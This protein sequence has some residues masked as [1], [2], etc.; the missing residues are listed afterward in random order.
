MSLRICSRDMRSTSF[1]NDSAARAAATTQSKIDNRKS[2][3]DWRRGQESNLP[4]LLRTD[5]GVE[6]REGHQAPFTLR[7]EEENAERSTF[8]AQ[9]RSKTAK[10]RL[11]G[12]FKLFNRAD[13]GVELW[14]VTGVEFGMEQLAIGAD[15]EGAAT[16]RDE[17][18]RLNA[19]AEL[20]NFGRQTD[21]L[22]R[23][24]SDDAVFDRYFGFH[25]VLL[26]D[27][28]VSVRQHAVKTQPN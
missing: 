19:L 6:D 23:V 3:M 12:L 7:E 10:I 27:S 26:S 9:R 13:D 25:R 22:R 20:E 28:N 21:G 1:R 14:P 11:C 17:G 16:G 4:R 24:V 15:F 2:R 8:N 18:E 5:H